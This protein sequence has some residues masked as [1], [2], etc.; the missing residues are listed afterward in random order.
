MLWF[1]C[2]VIF[3]R[4]QIATVLLLDY[5]II[6]SLPATIDPLD[7]KM[8][9]NI[10]LWG[11]ISPQTYHSCRILLI[12]NQPES[13]YNGW[14]GWSSPFYEMALV[15]DYHWMFT[16]LLLLSLIYILDVEMSIPASFGLKLVTCWYLLT[17]LTGMALIHICLKGTTW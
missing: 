9:R 3:L 2:P 4:L 12:L 7:L 1:S 11:E 5:W 6:R 14:P 17:F 15:E 10:L 8:D 13:T 16:R